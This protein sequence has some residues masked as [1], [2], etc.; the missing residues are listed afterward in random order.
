MKRL[1]KYI[2]DWPAWPV[3]ERPRGALCTAKFCNLSDR[4][5]KIVDRT[6]PYI[7]LVDRL[8]AIE[9]I[10]G[11]EYDMD[12]L[13]E[14]VQAESKGK[15]PKYTIGDTIYDRFGKPWTVENIERHSLYKKNEWLYKCGH[16]GTDDYCALWEF[17][18]FPSEEAALRREQEE[19]EP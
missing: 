7:Q 2:P 17:E 13:R 18:V 11:D 1:T 5:D 15:I 3:L 19:A 14:L 10:L 9:D 4:C 12:R 6:C 8:A 16:D